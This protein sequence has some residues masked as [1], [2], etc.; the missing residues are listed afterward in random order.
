MLIFE[1]LAALV[2][3]L[4]SGHLLII[5][6]PADPSLLAL[7]LGLADLGLLLL[8]VLARP[9]L[10]HHILL[11]F[12]LCCLCN[13]AGLHLGCSDY[14]GISGIGLFIK[15]P[16]ITGHE[17]RSLGRLG[18]FYNRPIAALLQSAT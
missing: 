10:T 6:A 8:P 13:L 15:L 11:E 7:Q 1:R 2:V 17:V 16:L 5:P 4:S 9:L 3:T 14:N 12:Q 18:L